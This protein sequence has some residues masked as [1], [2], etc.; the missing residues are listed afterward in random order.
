[1][2]TFP[3]TKRLT[4]NN[5]YQAVFREPDIRFRMGDILLLAK[6]NNTVTSRL[7]LSVSKKHLKHAVDRNIFK[8][9]TR[10]SF[11][12]QNNLPYCDI[13][14]IALKGIRNVSHTEL[15]DSLASLWKK[16]AEFPQK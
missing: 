9:M 5:E 7:G 4:H 14:I 15:T 6:K 2:F 11:R 16:L 13:I 10:E 3:R 12:K 1:L 8:R